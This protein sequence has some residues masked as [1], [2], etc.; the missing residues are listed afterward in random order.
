[1]P[2][3]E[4]N[5]VFISH[6]KTDEEVAQLIR[7]FLIQTGVKDDDIFCSSI[8][9]NDVNE[10]I[11]SEV[12]GQLKR[13]AVI[14]L[15]LSEKF[16]QSPYCLNEAGIAWYLDDEVKVIPIALDHIEATDM[17]GFLDSN[18]RLRSLDDLKDILAI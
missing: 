9:G 18:H 2:E 14:I 1:M 15:L 11:D 3:L 10:K 16:F 5:V 6:R 12:K 13:S 8:P 7:Q 4:R 17:V